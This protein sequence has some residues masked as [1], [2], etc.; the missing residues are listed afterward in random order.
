MR[1]IQQV[2]K[3]VEKLKEIQKKLERLKRIKGE[4][5]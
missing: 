3:S 2:L 5:K 4:K 1:L